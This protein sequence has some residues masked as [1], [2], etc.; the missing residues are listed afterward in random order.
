MLHP[1]CDTNP[2]CCAGLLGS[3]AHSRHVCF[4]TQQACGLFCT[5]DM[6]AVSHSK[7]VYCVKQ[8]TCPA[9]SHSRD[10]CRVTDHMCLLCHTAEMFVASHSRLLLLCH[11]AD[12]SAVSQGGHVG[13][14]TQQSCLV[15]RTADMSGVS[16]SRHACCVTQHAC[17]LCHTTGSFQKQYFLFVRPFKNSQVSH[18]I[19]TG[20][21]LIIYQFSSCCY[22]LVVHS[23][24][25]H[26][27]S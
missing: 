22:A 3:G 4:G 19:L 17:L 15:C 27:E 5:A 6:P 21:R 9:V 13:C 10:L 7:H 12:M 2:A 1:S 24:V 8:Q 11:T 23:C 20:L 14:V 25:G 26:V 18:Q 16:Q